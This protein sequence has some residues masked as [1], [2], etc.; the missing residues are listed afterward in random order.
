MTKCDKIYL[1]SC[2]TFLTN[3]RHATIVQ[4]YYTHILPHEADIKGLNEK[5][6]N[7]SKKMVGYGILYRFHEV[8]TEGNCG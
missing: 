3:S 1:K 7:S 6:A 5:E 4:Q 8:V 2:V